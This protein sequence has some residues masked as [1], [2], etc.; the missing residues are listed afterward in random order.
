MR[1]CFA[2]CPT[3]EQQQLIVIVSSL[4]LMKITK[5][6]GHTGMKVKADNNSELQTE[7]KKLRTLI[8]VTHRGRGRAA[9]S[10]PAV[11]WPAQISNGSE[12]LFMAQLKKNS[13][14]PPCPP[15]SHPPTHQHQQKSTFCFRQRKEKKTP[16]ALGET[17]E[18]FTVTVRAHA[19]LPQGSETKGSAHPDHPCFHYNTQIRMSVL[20]LQLNRG[21]G[22][23]KKKKI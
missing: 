20:S 3:K 23:K 13:A 12:S 11:T 4:Y 15:F 19:L 21:Q 8:V 6:C 9:L 2:Q 17:L 16:A 10:R 14:V 22:A 7:H 18:G 1:R 5:R